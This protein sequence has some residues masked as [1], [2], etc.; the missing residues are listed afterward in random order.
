GRH[1]PVSPKKMRETYQQMAKQIPQSLEGPILFIG[2]AETA[3]GLGAGIFDE[4][5]DR[6][7][8]ALYLTSTRHP[9]A[10][11]ELFGKFKENHSHAT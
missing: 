2:M 3:V 5:R 6:Y 7:P 10:D 8:Q 11:S 9:S 4:V 1:I